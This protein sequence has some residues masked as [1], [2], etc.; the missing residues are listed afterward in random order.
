MGEAAV[1]SHMKRAKHS[2][3]FKQVT[4]AVSVKDDTRLLVLVSQQDTHKKSEDA[5]AVA[6]NHGG[7]SKQIQATLTIAPVHGSVATKTDV[8]L[9]ELL[10]AMKVCSAHYSHNSCESSGLLF[11][12]MFPDSIIASSFTCGEMKSSYLYY[13]AVPC[14]QSNMLSAF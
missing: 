8:L 13:F 11:Q 10:W 4:T 12:K 9:A 5:A 14:L 3:L 2:Q 6:H 1:K 7:H